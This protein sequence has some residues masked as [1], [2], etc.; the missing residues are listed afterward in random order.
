ME[1]KSNID[2]TKAAR[3][4]TTCFPLVPLCSAR[5]GRLWQQKCTFL[6]TAGGF[7]HSLQLR[8]AVITENQICYDFV[9]V[10]SQQFTLIRHGN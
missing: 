4:H 7:N 6:D 1:I 9:H 8:L 2:N 3:T 10:I 5:L